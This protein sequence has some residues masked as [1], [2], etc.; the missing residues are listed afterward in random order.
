M[1]Q[2]SSQMN[3]KTN[4][5]RQ[6]PSSE[7]KNNVI[8]QKNTEQMVRDSDVQYKYK[9][10]AMQNQQIPFLFRKL[11]PYLSYQ[12][13]KQLEQTVDFRQK[14]TCL[15]LECYLAATQQ[16][17]TA[18]SYPI[19]KPQQKKRILH[20]LEENP[21]YQDAYQRNLIEIANN[22]A[23]SSQELKY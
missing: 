15:C 19:T 3:Q 21:N 5:K 4:G 13:Y 23:R 9:K 1:D 17:L 14:K 6:G 10:D 8:I 22:R 12:E 7:N 2:I 20:Q 18:G 16:Q 11:H